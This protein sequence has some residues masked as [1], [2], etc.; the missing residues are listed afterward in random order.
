MYAMNA[1]RR[2]F[3]FSTAW[4]WGWLIVGCLGGLAMAG[5]FALAA[6][7]PDD[8]GRSVPRPF[9]IA[10]Q[11]LDSALAAYGA[12]TGMQMLYNS[13]LVAGRWS[14]GV[15]GE[16]VPEEALRVLLDGA[17]LAARRTDVDAITLERAH[18]QS[19]SVN[20]VVPD[21]RFL[22]AVQAALLGRLCLHPETRPGTYRMVL[23]LWISPDQ[24]IQ[25]ARLLGS[26]GDPR[27]DAILAT[28]LENVSIDMPMP[29]GVPQPL[30][31]MIVPR[32][33][34]RGRECSDP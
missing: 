8:A 25:R 30:T 32:D 27:R 10:A 20:G 9:N 7:L 28:T 3:R 29:P 18:T 1:A 17:D 26:T 14:K 6:G 13:A 33:P 12:A 5:R 22:G 31:M 34:S 2:Q 23:Q 15:S 24:V 19:A 16:L 4:L 11:P 21:P